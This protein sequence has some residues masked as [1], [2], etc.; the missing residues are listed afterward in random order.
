MSLY[1]YSPDSTS[2]AWKSHAVHIYYRQAPVCVCGEK[3]KKVDLRD[4]YQGTPT[5]VICDGCDQAINAKDNTH[6]YLW[7]C[8][9]EKSGKGH[10]YGYDLCIKCGE[11]QSNY[12]AANTTKIKRSGS[13][14]RI[15]QSLHG[16]KRMR[17]YHVTDEKGVSGIKSSGFWMK[18]GEDGMFGGGIYFAENIRDAHYKAHHKGFLITADVIVGRELKVDSWRVGKF[19]FHDL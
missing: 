2:S 3:M 7:H 16:S 18:S 14:Y 4:C 10:A 15:S 5:G 6:R 1:T 19:T 8:A 11:N 17:L 13:A 12:Q 9:L